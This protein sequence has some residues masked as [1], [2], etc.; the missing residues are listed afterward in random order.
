MLLSNVM[1]D[2]ACFHD[3]PY[4]SLKKKTWPFAFL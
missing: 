2:C 4:Y 1:F 3:E